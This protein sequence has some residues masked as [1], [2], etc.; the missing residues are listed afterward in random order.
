MV[1]TAL[2]I[3]GFELLFEGYKRKMSIAAG[4]ARVSFI[5]SHALAKLARFSK[6]GSRTTLSAFYK[7][8]GTACNSSTPFVLR[9]SP[10]S[11]SG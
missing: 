11:A 2:V 8:I 10:H 6:V 7:I 5:L 9:L 3:G 4:I 1:T